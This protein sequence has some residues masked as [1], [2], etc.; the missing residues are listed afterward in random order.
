MG[1][2]LMDLAAIQRTIPHRPPFLLVDRI[3]ELEAD[4]RILGARDVSA[5]DPWLAGHFPDFP[6]MPGVLVVEA[7]AQ[8][9]AVLMMHGRDLAGQY[10]FFAGIDNTRFRRP[11]MAGDELHMKVTVLQRRPDA[12]RLEGVALVGGDIAARAEILAVL[13]S[14]STQ[15]AQ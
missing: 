10:P 2:A 7:L 13:R 12:C 11:V 14:R 6:V 8:T 1:V 4:E 3:L 9:A 5:D 15:E